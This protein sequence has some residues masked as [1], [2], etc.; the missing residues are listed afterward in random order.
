[1]SLSSYSRLLY[2][3]LP[4]WD[5]PFQPSF[6][7]SRSAPAFSGSLSAP[8]FQNL[9]PLV[10]PRFSDARSEQLSVSV[11]VSWQF[12]GRPSKLL[13]QNWLVWKRRSRVILTDLLNYSSD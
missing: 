6:S 2:P 11:S 9:P 10:P 13:F 7:T 12:Q 1:M 4:G 3:P 8:T 5:C